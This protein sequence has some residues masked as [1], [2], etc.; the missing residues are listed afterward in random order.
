MP[1]LRV[2]Q[3]AQYVNACPNTDHNPMRLEQNKIQKVSFTLHIKYSLC[4]DPQPHLESDVIA[5]K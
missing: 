1:S 4:F 2:F 5:S 3:P